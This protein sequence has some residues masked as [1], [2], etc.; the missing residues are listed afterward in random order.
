MVEPKYTIDS[1]AKAK[2]DLAGSVVERL[3]GRAAWLPLLPE[4]LLLCNDA[5]KR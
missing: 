3:S 5:V 2:P 1:V 4:M